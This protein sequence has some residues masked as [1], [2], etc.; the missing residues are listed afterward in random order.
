MAT[1]GHA[2]P[3]IRGCFGFSVPTLRL[4]GYAMLKMQNTQQG[5]VIATRIKRR[6]K[7]LIWEYKHHKISK[8]QA[9]SK[10]ASTEGWL[11]H[12][13]AHNLSVS[14]KINELKECIKH[15]RYSEAS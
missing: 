9:L 3:P 2:I 11:K 10:I 15:E 4:N 5:K 14:L 8:L 13:T 7:G 12:A 1:M 6:M